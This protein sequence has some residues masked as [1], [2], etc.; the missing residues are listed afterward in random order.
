MRRKTFKEL[1]TAT[2]QALELAGQVKELPRTELLKRA[3][4]ERERLEHIGELDRTGDVMPKKA[5]PCDDSLVGKELEIRWRYW[6]AAEEGERGKKKAAD[7]WC[8]GTVVQIAN[9][10]TD[11]ASPR[12]KKILDAGAV[13]IKWPVDKDFDEG[14]HYTWS[15]LTK[16][17]WNKEAVLGWR[18]TAT[19]LAKHGETRAPAEKRRK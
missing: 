18:Y 19:Q 8:V 14:E 2:P 12:C 15:I 6:R 13:C 3:E 9:G 11:K 17:N 4:D 16:E 5:P 1:G 10:T 7:I